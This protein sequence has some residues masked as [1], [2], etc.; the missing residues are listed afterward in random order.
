M[1][2]IKK[3]FN[4]SWELPSILHQ[5]LCIALNLYKMKCKCF[6]FLKSMYSHIFLSLAPSIYLYRDVW[7]H[8]HQVLILVISRQWEFNFFVASKF[9]S[10]LFV[11]FFS[12]YL[13]TPLICLFHPLHFTSGTINLY[14]LSVSLGRVF[15]LVS[16]GFLDS[17]SKRNHMVFVFL[18]R[19]HLA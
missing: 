15:C 1:F 13:L 10:V 12:F 9:F 18:C 3:I 2:I 16:F 5:F 8:V 7:K 6:Y 14:C 11:F 4:I 19:F 17:T